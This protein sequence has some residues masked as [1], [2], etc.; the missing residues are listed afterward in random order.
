MMLSIRNDTPYTMEV[1]TMKK[2]T[3]A[4][5]VITKILEVFHWACAGFVAFFLLATPGK[6]GLFEGKSFRNPE[7]NACGL[8]VNVHNSAGEVEPTAFYLFC[9][10]MVI[11][12]VL[13]AVIFRNIYSILKKADG[14]SPFHETNLRKLKEIGYISIA[15]PIVGL[16]ISTIIRLALGPDA[17][18]ISGDLNGFFMGIIVLCLTQYFAYGAQL[19]K[20]VDGLV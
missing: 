6:P 8:S 20:D 2:L 13:Y 3:A 17:A 15:V 14:G 18:E 4:G 7:F 16:V 11:L 9:L 1:R 19:E 5:K 12:C 10:G